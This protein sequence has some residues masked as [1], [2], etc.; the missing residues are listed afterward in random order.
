[1]GDLFSGR[2]LFPFRPSPRFRALVFS[3]APLIT[4][5]MRDLAGVPAA[6]GERRDLS[7]EAGRDDLDVLR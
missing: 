3:R 4:R 1:V 7:E 6:A 5:Q 2:V